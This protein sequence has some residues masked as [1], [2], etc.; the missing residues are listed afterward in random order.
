MKRSVIPACANQQKLEFH[1]VPSQPLH[2]N[3]FLYKADIQQ[4]DTEAKMKSWGVLLAAT[5][6]LFGCIGNQQEKQAYNAV[7]AL[8]R[9][10]KSVKFKNVFVLTSKSG[11]KFVCGEYSDKDSVRNGPEYRKFLWSMGL[12]VITDGNL[13]RERTETEMS[14]LSEVVRGNCQLGNKN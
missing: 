12:G 14:V 2:H 9:D 4:I 7:A 10:P 1:F 8:S 3:N 6:T 13:G 5:I 11:D